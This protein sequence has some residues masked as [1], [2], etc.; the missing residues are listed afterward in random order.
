MYETKVIAI[1]DSLNDNYIY[2]RDCLEL[3]ASKETIKTMMEQAGLTDE[4][5][6]CTA[7]Q[8]E[9][10]MDCLNRVMPERCRLDEL[11]YLAQR[12]SDLSEYER[13]KFEGAVALSDRKEPVAALINFT[14]NLENYEVVPNVD[15]DEELGRYCIKVHKFSS[16]NHVPSDLLKY[17]DYE[18]LGCLQRESE[19]GVYAGGKYIKDLGMSNKQVYDGA[20]IPEQIKDTGYYIKLWLT[21]GHELEGTWL[22][23]PAG[24][25]EML[26]ALNKLK[27]N[28]I[29]ECTVG[30]CVS[31]LPKLE[32]SIYQ[33]PDIYDFINKVDNLSYGID[34]MP[35]SEM[36]AK[37]KAALIYEDCTDLDFAADITQNL[38]CYDFYLSLSSAEEYGR[39]LACEKGYLSSSNSK[40]LSCLDF[41]EYGKDQMAI[42]GAMTTEYGMIVR[43]ENEFYFD[44]YTPTQQQRI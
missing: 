20:H 19:N 23:L 2:L 14:Y 1:N 30:K 29:S 36:T 43:N 24:E 39:K 4:H 11:N 21:S 7:L 25:D 5:A 15:N 44:Y 10:R 27:V 8:Y 31:I 16:L 37:F 40:I 18:K 13:M 17:L 6:P 41:E 9:C 35:N 32:D 12:L 3:P 26:A 42:R 28:D 38:D 33:H 34:Q 22:K